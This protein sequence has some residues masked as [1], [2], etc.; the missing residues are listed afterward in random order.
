M[1]LYEVTLQILCSDFPY[2]FENKKNRKRKIKEEYLNNLS[3][4]YEN[5]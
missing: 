4:T 2:I 1:Y 5:G 3:R